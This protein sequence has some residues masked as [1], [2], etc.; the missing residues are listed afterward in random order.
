MYATSSEDDVEMS[1][2]SHSDTFGQRKTT[3]ALT[4]SQT[5]GSFAAT[6]PALTPLHANI[7]NALHKGSDEDDGRWLK[8]YGR[9]RK[10]TKS[11]AQP[12]KVSTDASG[13]RE[14]MS[15]QE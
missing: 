11:N 10:S 15:R 7:P 14:G 13:E 1:S 6:R 3:R 5:E 4:L 12:W 8:G 9:G 2:P